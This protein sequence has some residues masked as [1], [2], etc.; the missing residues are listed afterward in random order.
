MLQCSMYV[1]VTVNVS[2]I[3]FINS[4]GLYIAQISSDSYNIAIY[5]RYKERESVDWYQ[6]N[7][8][9]SGPHFVKFDIVFDN[10]QKFY[11]FNWFHCHI[12]NYMR[13]TEIATISA[14]RLYYLTVVTIIRN[15]SGL[16]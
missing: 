12:K 5:I 14:I 13:L 16:F 11:P 2:K 6:V 15:K 10:V 1:D 9:I 3:S 7:W 8:F 4:Y